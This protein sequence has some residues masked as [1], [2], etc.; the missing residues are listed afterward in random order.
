MAVISFGD[1]ATGTDSLPLPYR[2]PGM[3]PR[4]RS[5]RASFFPLSLRLS[6]GTTNSGICYSNL[7]RRS[8]EEAGHRGLLVDVLDRTGE[9]L[10]DREHHDAAALLLLRGERDRVGDDELGQ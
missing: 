4:L 2:T 6:A 1:T 3:S 5:R 10:G 9:Q 8:D 7:A